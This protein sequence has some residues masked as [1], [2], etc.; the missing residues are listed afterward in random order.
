MHCWRWLGLKNKL[1]LS[2]SI[3]NL[4]RTWKY[5]KKQKKNL[6]IYGITSMILCVMGAVT[7]ILTAKVVLN[8]TNEK[9]NLLLNLAVI[10]FVFEIMRNIIRYCASRAGQ[11][12]FR[13]TLLSLQTSIATELLKIEA[14]EIDHNSSGIF[15]DRLNRDSAD[16][17]RIFEQLNYSV[18]EIVANIGVMIAIFFINKWVFLYFLIGLSILFVLNKMK[19]KKFF[20]HDKIY[21]KIA[22]KNTGL[23]TELVRGIRDIK[24]LNADNSFLKT[25]YE[26]LKKSN[27]ERYKMAKVERKYGLITGSFN[28]LLDVLFI[29]LGLFLISKNLLITS[30]FVVLYMYQGKVY[31]LFNYF[32]IFLEYLKNFNLSS[33]RVFEILENE[34]FEKEEFGTLELAN[35]NGDF[36]FRDV[37]FGYEEKKK[38][39][40][41]LNFKIKAN[42]T[43]AF[44]GKSGVG[45]STIFSL[46]TRLYKLEKGKILVDGH[47]I[48]HLTKNSLRDNISIITQSPYIFNFTIRENLRIVKPDM[49]EDEM[50]NACK[51]ACL[52]DFIMSLEKGY[53]TVVGEGGLTLSGGQRQRLA[54]ARALLKKTEIILFDEATSALDNE[55]QK[56]ISKAI[57]N[58]RGEYTIL[59]IAH[60]LSTIIDSDRI[61]VVEDGKITGE[62]SHKE[63][64]LNN[65]DYQ[66]L[67]QTEISGAEELVLN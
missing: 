54:I 30:N 9:W 31:N 4:K 33:S 23:I 52:H 13:E 62:G 67:Y 53:D 21:R 5:A 57:Y 17:A 41:D 42:E 25:M 11:L 22:E 63:L 24:I 40:K 46:L 12:F 20:E 61:L 56:S 14:K 27:E 49:T 8:M 66:N 43:V 37:T 60:R 19:L 36:E 58:M 2:E 55:T 47:N 26:R 6:I 16:I 44:V 7:P 3:H 50:I 64:L 15:I 35:I 48:N 65:K 34:K 1:K 32:S 28:D 39:L 59:I 18:T 51:T 29:F 38:I 45:K 10:L